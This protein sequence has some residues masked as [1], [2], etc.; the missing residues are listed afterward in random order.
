M[1]DDS[2]PIKDDELL[3]RRMNVK[4]NYFDPDLNAP[5]SPR[6]FRPHGSRDETGLSMFRS[7]FYETV[8][9]VAENERGAQY[10]IA[11]LRA[12]DLRARGIRV[13]PRPVPRLGRGHAELP[14]LRSDNRRDTDEIQALLA[15]LCI[16]VE[17]PY[18]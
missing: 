11:V 18:P 16:R 13:E 8:G 15:E 1:P 9:Q 3:Y 10:Y 5:P 12:G 6:A 7:Q 2:T 17:G 4:L 14:D